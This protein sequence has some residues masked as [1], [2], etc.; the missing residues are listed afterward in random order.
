VTILGSGKG[1]KN[2]DVND[3]FAVKAII[4]DALNE[5]GPINLGLA[6]DSRAELS[7]VDLALVS[8]TVS[9][10]E[11]ISSRRRLRGT[12]IYKGGAT[13]YLCSSDNNDRR[14]L[15][16]VEKVRTGKDI[17]DSSIS[18]IEDTITSY[19]EKNPDHCMASTNLKVKLEFFKSPKRI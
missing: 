8:E 7:V 15:T 12:W 14:E 16:T 11:E 6:S 10:S 9:D 4:K 18:F 3:Q 17:P 5:L 19:F 13:C 1:N 2:C